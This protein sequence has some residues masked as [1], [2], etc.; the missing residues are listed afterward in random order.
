MNRQTCLKVDSLYLL[1]KI[2]PKH[3]DYKTRQHIPLTAIRKEDLEYT[4]RDAILYVSHAVSVP[5]SMVMPPISTLALSRRT[6]MAPL[7][8]C[9]LPDAAHVPNR[10]DH[11]T[12]PRVELPIMQ[13]SPAPAVRRREVPEHL[14][15]S[16]TGQS[17]TGWTVIAHFT[18][19]V[20]S[21]Q[22]L[23]SRNIMILL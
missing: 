2:V 22:M 14:R 20:S 3:F 13:L 23:H 7:S 19:Q 11:P 21:S 18:P 4:Y 12:M 6:I 10:Q 17:L 8:S 5:S 1:T 9:R 16:D 15:D